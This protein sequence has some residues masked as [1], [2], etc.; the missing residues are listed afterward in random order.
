MFPQLILTYRSLSLLV[1]SWWKP[2]AWRSSCWMI[3]WSRQPYTDRE[4]SC[5]PP[6][7]PIVDQHLQFRVR[8]RDGGES[9]R[10]GARS[11]L[12]WPSPL[13]S[14]HSPQFALNAEVVGL[15]T[16]WNEANTGF[17]VESF[18]SSLNRSLFVVICNENQINF[19]TWW[20][21]DVFNTS[22]TENLSWKK[23]KFF[24]LFLFVS[25]FCK[26]SIA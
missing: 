17:L 9:W 1:C 23:S 18:H 7:L 15:A 13:L 6:S 12:H 10:P 3:P 4:S 22:H 25:G 8:Q 20:Y 5:C 26:K 11:T 24:S 14:P 19:N 2:S 16:I 21:P